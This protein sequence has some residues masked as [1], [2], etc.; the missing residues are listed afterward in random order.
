MLLSLASPF[1]KLRLN[2]R[3]VSVDPNCQSV[4]I[5]TGETIY[6]DL[7]VGADGVKSTVRETVVGRPVK[8]T[9]TGDAAYRALIP[10]EKM[11]SDPDLKVLI[12]YPE[13]ITWMG[14]ERH[15]V[16]YSIVSGIFKPF[17]NFT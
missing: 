17:R 14:P 2:S 10:T 8:P 7:I 4:T 11:I 12:D 5:Q 3:V 1:M 15:F 9:P 16:G 13:F 6:A